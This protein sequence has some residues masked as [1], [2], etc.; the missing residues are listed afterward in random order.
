MAI[1]L[2]PQPQSYQ[3]FLWLFLWG[4]PQPQ[5]YQLFLWLY[6]YGHMGWSSASKLPA[7][8]MAIPVGWLRGRFGSI[9]SPG[10]R[11]IARGSILT[12]LG[13]NAAPLAFRASLTASAVFSPKASARGEP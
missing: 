7:I 5:S 1:P 11:A 2:G 4:G 13:P 8:L 10:G 9:Q 3:A 6:S 12:L